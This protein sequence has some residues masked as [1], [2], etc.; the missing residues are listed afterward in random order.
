MISAFAKRVGTE[1]M[2]TWRSSVGRLLVVLHAALMVIALAN[3]G[4]ADP[5]G[6]NELQQISQFGFSMD[7][8]YFAGR[9]IHLNY[10]SPLM[11]V[12]ILADLP[13]DFGCIAVALPV[14]W[15]SDT[16]WASKDTR[17]SSATPWRTSLF[18]LSYRTAAWL[19]LAASVQ[20]LIVG[21]WLQRSL[22]RRDGREPRAI[23]WLDRHLWRVVAAVVVASAVVV[24][25][26]YHNAVLGLRAM[27]GA[28]TGK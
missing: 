6:A 24:P 13:S 10:E 27:E 19:L 14:S 2:R 23:A 15:L 9:Q 12:L 7:Y 28:A 1:I 18:V 25:I 21:S 20:W 26:V 3:K 16:I 4:P 17:A 5:T 22:R 11:Q 8:S